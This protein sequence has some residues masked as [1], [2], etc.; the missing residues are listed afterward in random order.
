MDWRFGWA[1]LGVTEGL[2]LLAFRGS[3]VGAWYMFF[4]PINFPVAEREL[5]Y[6]SRGDSMEGFLKELSKPL[7]DTTLFL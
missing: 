7:F 6:K 3:F 5:D 2:G 4:F 1:L